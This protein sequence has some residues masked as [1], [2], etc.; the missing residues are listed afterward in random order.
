M[1]Y[2]ILNSCKQIMKKKQILFSNCKVF[3]IVFHIEEFRTVKKDLDS[4]NIM[5]AKFKIQICFLRS[6]LNK[7]E[8]TKN[9]IYNILDCFKMLAI[10]QMIT[11][12]CLWRFDKINIIRI[13]CLFNLKLY[14][15]CFDILLQWIIYYMTNISEVPQR[16]LCGKE[17]SQTLADR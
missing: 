5:K 12:I 14:K 16:Q 10:W 1:I 9:L 3:L 8:I 13:K 15:T 17:L 7:Y 2:N 11:K 4:T 6:N